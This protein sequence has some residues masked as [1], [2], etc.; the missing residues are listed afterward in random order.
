M[1]Q[2]LKGC[3][4]RYFAKSKVVSGNTFSIT[5]PRNFWKFFPIG[6]R[7]EVMTFNQKEAFTKRVRNQNDRQRVVSVPHDEQFIFKKGT[8]V[9]IYPQDQQLIL[10]L[11]SKSQPKTNEQMKNERTKPKPRTEVK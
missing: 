8:K 6:S 5:I 9:R 1:K 11:V 7:V 2:V 10:K 3:D 4:G